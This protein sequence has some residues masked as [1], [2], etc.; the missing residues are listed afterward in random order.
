MTA[1]DSILIFNS[2]FLILH[3]NKLHLFINFKKDPYFK[4]IET[5]YINSIELV[6]LFHEHAQ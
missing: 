6:Q 2:S 3:L 4:L 5:L 1:R